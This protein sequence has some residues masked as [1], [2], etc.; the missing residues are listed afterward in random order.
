MQ[1]RWPMFHQGLTMGIGRISHVGIPP[2]LWIC[3]RG[4]KHV[5]VA[6]CFGQNAGCSNR[7]N[8]SIALHKTRMRRHVF[9]R[10]KS[11]P[12]N[13][14][15]IRLTGQS[16]HRPTHGLKGGL[17]NVHPVNFIGGYK[18]HGPRNGLGFNFCAQRL[19]LSCREFFAVIQW[20]SLCHLR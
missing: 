12:I 16:A 17:Q 4:L 7:C 6:M 2:I 19:S 14:E 11:I 10:N 18:G 8:L 1:G 20:Q 13:Q 5:C 3:F 15:V 9:R